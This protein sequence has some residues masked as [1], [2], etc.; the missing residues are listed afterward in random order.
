M[1]ASK[2]RLVIA[3]TGT[4]FG[5]ELAMACSSDD[6]SPTPSS[7]NSSTGLGFATTDDAGDAA[8]IKTPTD[9]GTGA[10]FW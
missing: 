4:V 6:P 1:R 5:A 8:P 9:P 2:L 7:S 10:Q 3:V